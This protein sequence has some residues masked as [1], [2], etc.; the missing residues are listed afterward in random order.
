MIFFCEQFVSDL[1]KRAKAHLFAQ[2]V[3]SLLS[4]TNCSICIHLNGYKH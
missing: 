1:F 3:Q 4:N 2:S